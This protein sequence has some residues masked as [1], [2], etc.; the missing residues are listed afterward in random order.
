MRILV[1]ENVPIQLLSHLAAAGH[2]AEHVDRLGLKGISN[3]E[4]LA[5]AAR[6]RYAVLLTGDTKMG[7]SQNIAVHDIAVVL[8]RGRK[9]QDAFR[10]SCRRFSLSSA[11]PLAAWSPRLRLID[12][13]VRLTCRWPGR[14]HS[15]PLQASIRRPH[16]TSSRAR[17]R[18]LG[19]AVLAETTAW[20]RPRAWAF[21][22]AVLCAAGDEMH[23]GFVAGRHPSAADVVIDAT[24]A[25]I[26]LATVGRISARR[27]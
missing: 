21:A 26:A 20:R 5:H 23:Q 10:R 3:G 17:A 1:D 24:G 27:P 14:S 18:D 12:R 22:L 11:P 6:E 4:L 19:A 9:T 2:Q 15:S 13:H 8:I 25:L 7:G 16:R